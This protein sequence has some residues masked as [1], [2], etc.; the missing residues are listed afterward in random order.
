MSITR[1]TGAAAALATALVIAGCGGGNNAMTTASAPAV[2]A[3]VP[4]G[5]SAGTGTGAS[6]SSF[7]ALIKNLRA[8]DETS[9][10]NPMSSSVVPPADESSD[11]EA[12]SS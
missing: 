1:K 10:P 2:A 3:P 7:M 12:L 5:A 9:E 4:T 11:P 8:D 6:M